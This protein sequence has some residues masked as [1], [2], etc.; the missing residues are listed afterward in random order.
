MS[1]ARAGLA[2]SIAFAVF[3]A[4]QIS[5][6]WVFER[7]DLRGLGV[8]E[9]LPPW[10]SFHLAWNPGINFGL[11]A[12]DARWT[13]WALAGLALVVAAGVLIWAGRRAGDRLFALGAGLLAGGA[14]GNA[15]DR[16][17]H[18]AVADFLNVSCCGIRNPFAFNIADIA[19]FL[20]A[21]LVAWRSGSPTPS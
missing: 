19:I 8:I 7:L 14:L 20:G 6:W 12:S 4:D 17:L 1:L 2:G 13:K 5:K 3:A 21:L 10:L 16:V 11:F 18:G 15:L 9:V